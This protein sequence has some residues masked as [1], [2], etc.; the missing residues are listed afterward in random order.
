MPFRFT[1]AP[2]RDRSLS[3]LA[4][5]SRSAEVRSP[6]ASA[7][8]LM[9]KTAARKKHLLRR[10]AGRIGRPP[11]ELAGE[12][13]ERI[14]DAARS[15][16]LE[17]GLAGASIDEI[18]RLARAGKPTIYARFSTKEALFEAVG[19][20]NAANVVARFTDLPPAGETTEE[21]LIWV[22]NNILQRL[23][24]SDAMDF[25]RLSIAESRRF[26]DIAGVGR[27]ARERGAQAV[28]QILSEVAKS[29]E[30]G[31]FPAFAP[32]RLP[33]TTQFFLDLVVARLFVRALFG[34]DL[35]LLRAEIGPHVAGAVTF[36]LAACRQGAAD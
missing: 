30:I 32:E 3:D 4:F 13:D 9:G 34:E 29:D 31:T 14:L 6:H 7:D 15:I 19:M 23:L 27:M 10:T 18:A 33:A 5:A 35:E 8:P 21:R 22:G 24:A 1:F 17:R 36:F 11:R 16:F 28:T 2:E 26:P 25:I 12:V 20:R